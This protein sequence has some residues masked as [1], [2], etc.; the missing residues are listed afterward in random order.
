MN[1]AKPTKIKK[2]ATVSFDTDLHGWVEIIF[3]T[4]PES[5]NIDVIQAVSKSTN[6]QGADREP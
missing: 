6:L 2:T 1:P 3:E 4:F 5:G